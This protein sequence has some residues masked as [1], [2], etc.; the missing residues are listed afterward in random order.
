MRNRES[1]R[2][3]HAAT[4][5]VV[6]AMMT[7]AATT[8]PADAGYAVDRGQKLLEESAQIIHP[9]G[10]QPADLSASSLIEVCTERGF[11][12][13]YIPGDFNR[14]ETAFGCNQDVC[15]WLF[16]SG[17][18]V[19]TWLT[20]ASQ[21]NSDGTICNAE[22]YFYSRRPNRTTYAIVDVN[23]VYGCFTGPGTFYSHFEGGGSP[24]WQN[25]TRLGNAWEPSQELSGFPT[26]LVH[27]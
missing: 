20:T 17:L 12:S 26:N 21:S 3:A 18:T 7:L 15:Q 5:L 27:S 8:S 1:G 2:V 25:G 4:T 13:G 19:D 11:C 6:L 10:I 24:T 16:G 14:I 22:A 23:T 9:G